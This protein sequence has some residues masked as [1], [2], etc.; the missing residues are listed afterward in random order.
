[1][2]YFQPGPRLHALI[3][4]LAYLPIHT[5][6]LPVT[7][8]YHALRYWLVPSARRFPRL[9]WWR[10][11]FLNVLRVQSQWT[12]G[13]WVNYADPDADKRIASKYDGDCD[14]GVV[15]VEPMRGE[16]PRVEVL[17][18]PA[19]ERGVVRGVEVTGFWI[20]A[21]KSDGEGDEKVSSEGGRRQGADDRTISTHPHARANAS[22]TSSSG[23]DTPMATRSTRIRRSRWPSSPARASSVRP[24]FDI[25]D[26]E[27]STTANLSMTSLPSLPP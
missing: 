21:K 19:V 16:A 13:L 18:S 10:Y 3:D 14:V 6:V 4:A 9:S 11:V 26:M 15:K 22:S 23:E 5:T 25:T 7:A 20:R 24:P 1:M 2:P 8:A 27:V 12:R 17:A